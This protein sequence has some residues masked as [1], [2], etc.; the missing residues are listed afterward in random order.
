MYMHKLTSEVVSDYTHNIVNTEAGKVRGVKIDSTYIFRG[1]RY[2]EAERFAMPHK[3]QPWEGVRDAFDYGYCAPELNTPIPH[4]QFYV[5]HYFYP[6][7]EACQYL[8]IWTQH[9]NDGAKRPVMV[10]IHGGGWFS[11]SGIEIYSYDGE[12]LSVYKDVVVISL[13]HRLNVLGY[14][15]LSAYGEK[16]ANSANAGLADLVAA[17]Q[18]IHDNITG[19]GGDPDNVTIFGQSGGGSKVISLMQT[20]AADGLYHKAIIQSGGVNHP[21][22]SLAAAEEESRYMA[23]RVV[24]YGGSP[25]ELEK[26]DFYDL[27]EATGKAI[28][29]FKQKYGKTY[30]WQPIANDWF[31]G[32][33]FDS[34]YRKETMNIPMLVG[35]VFGEFRNNYLLRIGEGHK[36]QWSEEYKL[37]MIRS[38]YGEAADRVI[39]AFKHA[40]PGRN[41]A[42][43]LFFDK[44][45]RAGCLEFSTDR[46]KLG[47]TVYNWLF[48]L[49]APFFG[50]TVPWHN[51]EEPYVFHNV[52]YIEAQYE[53]GVSETLQDLMA[54]AWVQFAETGNPNIP[55]LPVWEKVTPEHVPTMIFDRLCYSTVDHDKELIEAVPVVQSGMSLGNGKAVYAEGINPEVSD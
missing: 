17:L 14:L 50:G 48:D 36:N 19:F 11:G 6:Q 51:A 15:N 1:I 13:N 2:A 49:E 46:A 44:G 43:C 35:N 28:W 7:D 42:D 30:R 32:H 33:P 5:P 10:W 8:N 27:A 18:W 26:L 23:E 21:N 47:G 45:H 9:I 25:E 22:K 55:G 24:H 53:P 41:L 52:Q 29:D 38:F 40:Y 54:A 20:P 16:Y 4:D 34:S 3:V 31:A 37:E 39:C 12:N